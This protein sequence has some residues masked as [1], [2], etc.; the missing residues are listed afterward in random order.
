V[1]ETKDETMTFRTAGYSVKE[2]LRVNPQPDAKCGR[3]EDGVAFRHD[4]EGGWVLS[5]KDLESIYLRAKKL[6]TGGR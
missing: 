4:R 6:Q 2:V 5:F 1:S 3:I